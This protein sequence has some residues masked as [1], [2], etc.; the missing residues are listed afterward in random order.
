MS[1]MKCWAT[2]VS[3]NCGN[4]LLLTILECQQYLVDDGFRYV[5][6]ENWGAAKLNHPRVFDLDVEVVKYKVESLDLMATKKK[7]THFF[8]IASRK[9]DDL[10]GT[11]RL[12][13]HDATLSVLTLSLMATVTPS[14]SA[15][16]KPRRGKQQFTLYR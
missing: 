9:R 10:S 14:S 11:G 6:E 3:W 4:L 15:V 2:A 16:T 8:N 5:V 1:I 12:L 13:R 7:S